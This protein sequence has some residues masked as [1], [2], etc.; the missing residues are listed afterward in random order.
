MT[1]G[2]CNHLRD[3]SMFPCAVIKPVGIQPGWLPV[4]NRCQM[5]RCAD[6]R[7]ETLLLLEVGTVGGSV[8]ALVRHACSVQYKRGRVHM[9]EQWNLQH[10]G[11]LSA[12]WG[13]LR[14]SIRHCVTF[15]FCDWLWGSVKKNRIVHG[16][17]HAEILGTIIIM[18]Q[19]YRNCCCFAV[20]PSTL[21]SYRSVEEEVMTI[22]LGSNWNCD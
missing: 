3:L 2:I 10:S 9:S 1:P 20:Q 7:R 12:P 8:P 11:D 22:D 15:V 19:F 18:T 6:V 16:G 13:N 17:L 4:L 5:C 21:F 14:L